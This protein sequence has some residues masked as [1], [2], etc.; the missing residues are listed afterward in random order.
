MGYPAEIRRCQHIKSDG[1]QCGSPA[2]RNDKFC[3]FHQES[4]P[5]R[6]EI[7]SP[8]GETSEILVPVFEDAASIQM[9]V[10]RIAV[11]ILQD[12]ID[13]KKA[14]QLLYALQIAAS[15]L[16]QL[17]EEKPRPVQVVVDRDKVEEVPL[18]MTQWSARGAKH[19]PD[20]RWEAIEEAANA[21]VAVNK[22][23]AAAHRERKERMTER[24]TQLD[25]CLDQIETP[26]PEWLRSELE[27]ARAWMWEEV[28]GRREDAE[29]AEE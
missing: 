15:N 18:G 3:H 20:A 23:W 29:E 7:K 6:V 4:R 17:K 12:K 28:G 26:S 25:D 27:R 1:T 2:L 8:A 19:D 14:G 21:A 11:L 22:E 9:M 16:K 13:S 10:R 5:E 24:A